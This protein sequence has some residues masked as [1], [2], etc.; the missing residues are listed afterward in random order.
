MDVNER[1]NFTR[2]F[3]Q[4][5]VIQNI[6]SAQNSKTKIINNP[7]SKWSNVLNKYFSE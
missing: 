3:G 7:I 2:T 4:R 1:K 5:I 6:Q